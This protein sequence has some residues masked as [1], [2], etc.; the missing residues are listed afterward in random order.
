MPA[1][2]R[3]RLTAWLQ[4]HAPAER[5]RLR[6]PTGAPESGPLAPIYALG[7]GQ[8]GPTG[9]FDQYRF[10]AHDE[11]RREKAAMD[12]LARDEGWEDG[13]WS[14]RWHPFASD[15][16]G[17]LLLV[18]EDSDAVIEFLHDDD[19]RPEL[20]PS[21]EAFVVSFVETLEDGRRTW[22]DRMGIVQVSELE[23]AASAR[24]AR[25]QVE[26]DAQRAGRWALVIGLGVA[27]LFTALAIALDRFFRG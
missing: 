13:W 26:A 2:L 14:A 16:A 21:A 5:V 6:S 27:A 7:D 25:E 12:R 19:A 8:A 10:L 22:D 11:A 15:G 4:R 20:A 23:R 18:D 3:D 9:L 24:R 17:Q 1:S